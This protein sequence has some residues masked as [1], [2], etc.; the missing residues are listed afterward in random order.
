MVTV[1]LALFVFG[2]VSRRL[3]TTPLTG[4]FVFTTLGLLVGPAMFGLVAVPSGHL[5]VHLLA[6]ITLVLVLFADAVHID[7]AQLRRD[8]DLPVRMLLIGM[9]LSLG[10]GTI[11][12]LGL[13]ESLPLLEAALLAAILVP[14][15]AALGQAVVS[16]AIVPV[17]IRTALTVESGLNDG[18]A[19]PLV[20]IFASLA[21]IGGSSESAATLV[22]FSVRQVALGP[23]TGVLLGC[24]CG[25][26]VR[27]AYGAR[28]MTREAEGIM[29]LALAF[30]LF[31]VAESIG[32]SGFIAVFVGGL[33]FGNVLRH[34]C[35]F[36]YDFAETE[37]RILMLLTF[38]ALGATMI[39]E[40]ASAISVRLLVFALLALTVMRIVPVAVS[41]LGTGV[42]PATSLFLGW[43]GPRG[44]ASVLFVLVVLEESTLAESELVFAAATVTVALSVLLHGVSAAQGARYYGAHVRAM[45]ECA[46]AVTVPDMPYLDSHP[47]GEEPSWN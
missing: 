13:F 2:L 36:L 28:W 27:R 37:G 30:G 11:A 7:L 3:Q 10:I 47:T 18:I 42:S 4:P 35:E 8:H 29:A 1:T 44:L 31:A 9:P 46:E 14:T 41:L 38:L 5:A 22:G 43:F 16:Q 17:R 19:L 15:D 21:S 26:L 24:L 40:A 6:E 34:R 39:P 45:G 25:L 32:G 33:S 12:A 23:L 20:L